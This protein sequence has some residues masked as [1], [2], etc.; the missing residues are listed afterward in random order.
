[1][2]VR[3]KPETEHR[4]QELAEETGRT[5]D[6]LAEEAITGYL[7]ELS[8]TR[9]ALNSRYE[10][11]QSGRIAPLDGEQVFAILRRKSLGRSRP[12]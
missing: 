3:F 11:L 7:S 12:A 2:E 9:E 5:A 6:E 8:E 10:D 1:M 4:L